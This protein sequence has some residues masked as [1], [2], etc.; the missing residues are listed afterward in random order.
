MS[1]RWKARISGKKLY[2]NC[3]HNN[4]N[5]YFHRMRRAHIFIKYSVYL[6][7]SKK[8]WNFFL[9]LF[10]LIAQFKLLIG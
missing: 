5:L 4:L 7:L 3:V 2:V 8:L 6:F 10:K 9:S 1:K